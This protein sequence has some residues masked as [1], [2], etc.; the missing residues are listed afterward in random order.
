MDDEAALWV[1]RH[2]DVG[3]EDSLNFGRGDTAFTAGCGDKADLPE[4]YAR[5]EEMIVFHVLIVK[6]M[7]D[8]KGNNA[9]ARFLAVDIKAASNPTRAPRWKG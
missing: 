4:G 8:I 9:I 2:V 5:S 6:D 1:V 3:S 7:A